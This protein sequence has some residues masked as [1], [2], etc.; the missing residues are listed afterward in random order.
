MSKPLVYIKDPKFA[1]VPGTVL[2]TEGTKATVSVPQYKDEQ[3][4]TSDNGRSAKKPKETV[5]NLKDYANGVLPLQNVDKNGML[6]EYADM[7]K[8]PSLHEAGIMYNMKKRH[9]DGKPYTRTG[10]IVIAINPF[11][12]FT[13]LYTPQQQ[14]KLCG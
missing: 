3:S 12:W 1:W 8:L 5:V 6:V 13:H 4:I 14:K 10:N 11:Q 2:K 9:I 7:V